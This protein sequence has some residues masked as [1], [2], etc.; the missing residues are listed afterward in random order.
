MSTVESAIMVELKDQWDDPLLLKY[1]PPPTNLNTVTIIFADPDDHNE[2]INLVS[3]NKVI[4]PDGFGSFDFGVSG[5]TLIELDAGETEITGLSDNTIKYVFCPSTI[6]DFPDIPVTRDCKFTF[7]EH[8]TDRLFIEGGR[9]IVLFKGKLICSAPVDPLEINDQALI[10]VL[11]QK[12]QVFFE[13][14]HIDLDNQYG[15]TGIS[16]G[17]DTTVDY[18]SDIFIQNCRIENAFSNA[19]DSNYGNIQAHL[20]QPHGKHRYVFIDRVTGVT[21]YSGIYENTAYFGLDRTYSNINLKYTDYEEPN[22]LAASNLLNIKDNSL[23]SLAQQGFFSYNFENVFAQ[24]RQFS[25]ASFA[26]STIFPYDSTSIIGSFVENDAITGITG[27]V[28][29]YAP[30]MQVNGSIR[31]ASVSGAAFFGDYVVA[32]RHC[33]ENYVSPGYENSIPFHLNM[34]NCQLFL[35]TT[36]HKVFG[37]AVVNGSYGQKI[38]SSICD[39]SGKSNHSTLTDCEYYKSYIYGNKCLYFN[40]TTSKIETGESSLGNTNLF[41]DVS[42]QFFFSA[43]I[44]AEDSGY[45]ISKG[46]NHFCIFVVKTGAT[47][48]IYGVARSMTTIIK[49]GWNGSTPLFIAA[50]WNGSQLSYYTNEMAI[51]GV[52]GTALAE[53]GD[54]IVIG[55][56]LESSSISF[57]KGIITSIRIYDIGLTAPQISSIY[58]REMKKW[59]LDNLQPAK[60]SRPTV[61]QN[62]TATTP[63]ITSCVLTWTAPASN[64]GSSFLDY[65]IRY[66]PSA[67]S[68]WTYFNLSTISTTPSANITGLTT[69][70]DYDF[71]VYATNIIGWSDKASISKFIGAALPITANLFLWYDMDDGDTIV[72]DSNNNITNVLD[73][74]GN[75]YHATSTAFPTGWNATLQNGNGGLLVNGTT[76]QM[77]INVADALNGLSSQMTIFVVYKSTTPASFQI[78]SQKRKIS[79]SS[80]H[81]L[82]NDS[83]NRLFLQVMT[84]G[85]TYSTPVGQRVTTAF[86]GAAHIACYRLNN[87]A[88]IFDFDGVNKSTFTYNH[89]SGFLPSDFWTPISKING[90][91]FEYVVYN[92][93]LSDT[94][95][96]TVT[97][98]LKTKWGIT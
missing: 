8:T 92:T 45:V 4:V 14:L 75:D 25:G 6:L 10:K 17:S 93:A 42:D 98:Y 43:V 41:C 67:S 78:V 23:L 86:N 85:G 39:I 74:S 53:T 27:G 20:I 63:T 16:Y 72:Y 83:S 56:N 22:S 11:N 13:G 33:G 97:N 24:K 1:S 66:K 96:L 64:G 73:K 55:T 52:V 2:T 69:N 59:N 15:R 54:N 36:N 50:N 34:T 37:S 35:D 40:G 65:I 26:N 77:S 9:N 82:T 62:L 88:G 30:E 5:V 44:Q 18:L 29:K 95:K 48:T 3:G 71:E 12:G 76:S 38:P 7:K 32:D 60:P 58:T 91:Y 68:T 31:Q 21:Q 79:P 19:E 51:S 87:G 61:V 80:Q 84:D 81:L 28:I 49:S 46:G 70:T 57:F 94:D 89:G 90:A 47:F